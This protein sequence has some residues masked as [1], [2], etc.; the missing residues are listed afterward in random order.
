MHHLSS[1]LV[2]VLLC[3]VWLL[4]RQSE[5]QAASTFCCEYSVVNLAAARPDHSQSAHRYPSLLAPRT[6][7]SI[8]YYLIQLRL[9]PTTLS[10]D[11]LGN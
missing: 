4:I 3:L 9:L 8:G 1:L 11:F 10:L 2:A 6:A 5:A 7:K